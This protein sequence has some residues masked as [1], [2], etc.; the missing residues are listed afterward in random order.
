MVSI[1]LWRPL[2]HWLYKI[3]PKQARSIT[4]NRRK[5]IFTYD[6]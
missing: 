3:A 6:Q 5:R 2:R 1:N 4:D